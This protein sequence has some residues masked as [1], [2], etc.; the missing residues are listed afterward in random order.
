[1]FQVDRFSEFPPIFKNTE[2]KMEDVGTYM[3]EYCESIGRT[4]CVKKS[5]I[6]SMHGKELVILTPL[7]KKYKEMGMICD[8]IEWIMEYTPKSV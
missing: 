6:S 5:L 1:M 2:I 7:F 4:T 8:D 3:Q